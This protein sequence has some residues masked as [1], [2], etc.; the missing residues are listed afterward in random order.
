MSDHIRIA[1]LES[2][3]SA[4]VKSLSS[5]SEHVNRSRK[6]VD[7]LLKDGNSYYGI[8]T[9][10]GALASKKISPKELEQ[11]QYNIIVSHSVGVGELIPKDISR[12]MLQLKIHGLS[13]GYSGI[14][15]EVFKRLV[16]F[17]E[18]DLVPAVPSQGSLGASGDLA[19]LAHLSLPLLGMGSFWSE[20]GSTTI[21]TSEVYEKLSLEPIKLQPKDGLALCNGTQMMGAYGSYVLTRAI[22][23]LKQFDIISAMTLDAIKGSMSPFDA[24]I[25]LLRP[26]PGQTAVADNFRKL[27]ADSEILASEK[28]F[29]RVQDPYSVRCIP[30]VHGACRDTIAHALRVVE[31]EIN[32]VTDNPI[33]CEEGDIVSGGNFHGQP[34]AFALDF[35]AIALAE[36]ANISERRIYLLLK[37]IGDLP[38]LLLDDTGV[39]SG[40]MIPQYTAASLVSENK[41]L[42]HPA[43]VDSIPSCLGQEDHVS[44]GSISAHKLYRIFNNVEN[45]LSIEA[46]TSAQAL[47]F[48]TP[49]KPGRGVQKA[50]QCIREIA[51][52]RDRDDYFGD[53]IDACRSLMQKSSLLKAVEAEV[54]ELA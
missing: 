8:N 6:I 9:G 5:S 12:V 3:L 53:S 36:M 17:A 13:L 48:R 23:L 20:D 28:I 43:S 21:R 18:N 49:L 51:A 30:Q 50:H 25:H 41:V 35:A 24:R 40:F 4:R 16:F 33:V 37:G 10:F 45:V 7:E 47:D 26:H 46:L 39:N 54:G 15:E 31:T 1:N 34:I 2:D 22:R 27:L 19:P 42:C 32:S 14:S 11:L 38:K 44:M 52:H 29:T